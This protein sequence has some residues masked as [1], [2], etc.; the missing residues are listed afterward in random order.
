MY[1][2]KLIIFTMV[3]IL[4]LIT[5]STA[6]AALESMALNKIS[7][8]DLTNTEKTSFTTGDYLRYAVEY[9]SNFLRLLHSLRFS[10]KEDWCGLP[11]TRMSKLRQGKYSNSGG[12]I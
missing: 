10:P 7:V 8:T 1:R 2:A 4:S 12:D 6:Q 3:L 9:T 11:T 5:G